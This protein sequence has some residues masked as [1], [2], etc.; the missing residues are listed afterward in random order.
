MIT[1]RKQFHFD[2][3]NKRQLFSTLRASAIAGNLR[4]V[5][6]RLITR[7]CWEVGRFAKRLQQC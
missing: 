6:M 7:L 1:S 3:F 2:V 4:E 5:V